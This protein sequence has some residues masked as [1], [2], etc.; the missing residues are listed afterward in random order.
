MMWLVV[1]SAALAAVIALIALVFGATSTK[2]IGAWQTL[3][4]CL[5]A[6]VWVSAPYQGPGAPLSTV[7]LLSSLAIAGLAIT[8]GIALWRDWPSGITLSLLA[9]GLQLA[10]VSLPVVQ[11][12]STLGPTLG[13]RL[14]ATTITFNLGMYGRGGLV[15]LPAGAA[16]RFPLDITVNGIAVVALFALWRLRRSRAVQAAV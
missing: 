9:Q 16:Y 14:T 7:G 3:G 15:L 10:W 11:F 4:G 1:G 2:A 13:L 6:L 5:I 12:G 8:A